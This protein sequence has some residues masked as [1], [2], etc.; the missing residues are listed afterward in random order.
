[1]TKANKGINTAALTSIGA[2]GQPEFV[3]AAEDFD[4]LPSNERALPEA[5]KNGSAGIIYAT[6]NA[7]AS[8]AR[9]TLSAF[10]AA[11]SKH[12]LSAALENLEPV[13][14]ILGCRRDA[15]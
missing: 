2:D 9:Q 10:R 4:V 7:S 13:S 11:I 8:L 6:T 3:K 5:I 12:P 1:M 15:V 14:G